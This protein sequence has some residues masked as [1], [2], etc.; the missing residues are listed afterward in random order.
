MIHNVPPNPSNEDYAYAKRLLDIQNRC[1]LEQYGCSFTS[2]VPTNIFGPNDNFNEEGGHVLPGL[3]NK[4]YRAKTDGGDFVV[5]GSGNPLRQFIYSRDLAKLTIWALRNY[6][7]IEP[8]ILCPNPE[9]ELSVSQVANF[10]AEGLSFKGNLRFDTSKADGQYRKTA[11]NQKLMR[12]YPEFQ[13][14]PLKD[15]IKETCD[16]YVQN[17]DSIRI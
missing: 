6:S 2:L 15:A 17:L 9:D 12:L 5:W 14:T 3:I 4:C 1:Y 11:T 16:W 13:F 10:V 7:D 8:L